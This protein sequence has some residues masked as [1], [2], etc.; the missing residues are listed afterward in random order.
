M[1]KT[2]LIDQVAENAELTKAKAAVAVESVFKAIQGALAAGD[3]VSLIGFGTFMVTKRAGRTGRNPRTNEEIQIPAANLPR[4]R[5]GQVLKDAMAPVK[6]VKPAAK[7]A[8]A[9][10]KVETKPVV[11]PAAK[12]AAKAVKK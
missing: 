5:P 6:E 8:A 3:R 2:E 9:A 1:N 4:F 10:A 12:P 7:P 11:K